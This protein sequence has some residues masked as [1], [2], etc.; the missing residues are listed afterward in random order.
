MLFLESPDDA[1][2][3]CQQAGQAQDTAECC[4]LQRAD[5][6]WRLRRAVYRCGMLLFIYSAATLFVRGGLQGLHAQ[7]FQ[8]ATHLSL[9]RFFVSGTPR[10]RLS[11]C[12]KPL[13]EPYASMKQKHKS[14]QKDQSWDKRNG[15][16]LQQRWL[17][18][19][20]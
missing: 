6:W 14:I 11:A 2:L 7:R 9:I 1:M 13:G 4:K 18:R 17:H 12:G 20:R 15:V 3:P 5:K 16:P 19:Q 10:L 8:A